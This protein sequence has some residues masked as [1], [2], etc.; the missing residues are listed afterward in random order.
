M[1]KESRTSFVNR[2]LG[3]S[4][5]STQGKFS[6][7]SDS[8]KQ[9]LFSLNHGNG[10]VILSPRWSKKGYSHSLKHI[11][12]VRYE[13][14]ELLVFQ[15]MTKK[16][17]SGETVAF[18]FNPSIEKRRLLI[19][20][21]TY[22]AVSIDGLFGTE[23]YEKDVSSFE[24]ATKTIRVNVY[25][26]CPK[27]RKACLDEYGYLCKVCNFDFEKVYGKL[28]KGFIHV[29]HIVP[30]SKINAEYEVDPLRD[31]LPVCPNCHE[32]LHRNGNIMLPDELKLLL[33][34]K[35]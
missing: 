4:F 20:N 25:E 10:D 35:N 13:G 12:K 31:L 26:R 6:Y 30:L 27:A 1:V 16:N 8:K 11:D 18:G 24:G 22:K 2:I 7:C 15:T 34:I 32:M 9:V 14:Y 19:E 23:T 33:T 21:D 5:K 3:L 28:G 17:K 29:H